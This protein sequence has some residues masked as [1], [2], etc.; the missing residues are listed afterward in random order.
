VAGVAPLLL[1]LAGCA[2]ADGKPT[3]P[4]LPVK[5]IDQWVM[6][7]DEYRPTEMHFTVASAVS[8]MIAH[9]CM[10]ES[11]EEHEVAIVDPATRGSETSTRYGRKLFSIAIASAWGYRPAPPPGSYE[12][13]RRAAIEYSTAR[14]EASPSYADALDAC[15]ARADK[16]YPLTVTRYQ[17]ATSLAMDADT[18]ALASEEVESSAKRWRSCLTP[19]ISFDVPSSP[20]H[21]P[22]EAIKE[23]LGI[24]GGDLTSMWSDGST[25]SNAEIEI[26]TVDANCRLESG[27]TQAYYEASWNE[28]RELLRKHADELERARTAIEEDWADAVRRLNSGRSAE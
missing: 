12:A 7:L 13:D 25:A 24:S 27:F 21:M 19:K 2:A 17:G 9:A 11:G 3:G 20:V 16:E 18:V 14:G 6:P 4:D 1:A 26:A 8:N 22:T 28:Q 10:I 5:N 15:R 23:E